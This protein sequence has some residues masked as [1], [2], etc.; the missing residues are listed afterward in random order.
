MNRLSGKVNV[1]LI[2]IVVVLILVG[3][4]GVLGLDTAKTY[5]SGAAGGLEPK[6]VSA[7]AEGDKATITW[8]SEKESMGVVEYGTSPASLLLRTPEATATMNH[9]VVLSPLRSGL[10]YYFRIRVGDEVYDNNGIPYSFKTEGSGESPGSAPGVTNIPS[11]V[12]TKQAQQGVDDCRSGMDYNSDGV[13][14]AYDLAYCK[15]HGMSGGSLA[16]PSPTAAST[17]ECQSGVD[18]DGNGVVNSFDMVKCLQ[19]RGD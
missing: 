8:T 11:L 14:N 2:I 17:G 7:S 4:L 19:N 12:P 3:I 1:K 16:A 15:K 10:S 6:G 18:Y 13:V 5:L 9:S